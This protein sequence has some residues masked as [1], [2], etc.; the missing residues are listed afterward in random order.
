[1][2]WSGLVGGARNFDTLT[3][4]LATKQHLGSEQ[5]TA[6]CVVTSIVSNIFPHHN[7]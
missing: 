3:N 4:P 1:M 2:A 7:N 5:L 6:D